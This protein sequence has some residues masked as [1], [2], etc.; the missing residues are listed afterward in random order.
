M[1]DKDVVFNDG[2][3]FGEI[4]RVEFGMSI[5]TSKAKS[6]SVM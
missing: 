4:D 5:A 6:P 3:T 2:I 1:V